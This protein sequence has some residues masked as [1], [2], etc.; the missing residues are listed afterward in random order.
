MAVFRR[1]YPDVGVGKFRYGFYRSNV[2]LPV[3]WVIVTGFGEQGGLYISLLNY[4]A[5]YQVCGELD[6]ILLRQL[7]SLV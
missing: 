5:L 2:G 7:Q 6:T 1:I 4:G 3:K